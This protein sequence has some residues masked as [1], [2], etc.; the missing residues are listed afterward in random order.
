MFVDVK[1]TNGLTLQ[2][3][4]NKIIAVTK[5]EGVTVYCVYL[6]SSWWYIIDEENY[7]KVK[8]AIQ[9]LND[10]AERKLYEIHK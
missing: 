1:T 10:I 3:N 8:Q 4:L 6:D 2:L 9:K 5:N 7:I